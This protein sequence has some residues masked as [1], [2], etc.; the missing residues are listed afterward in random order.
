MRVGIV[1]DEGHAL[2]TLQ[3]FF[4]KYKEQTRRHIKVDAFQDSVKFI[5]QYRMIYDLLL[6]DIQMPDLDG[7][8]LAEKIRDIDS[9]VLIIFVTNM[10]QYAVKGYKVGAL[11]Y[12]LKPVTYFEF[13]TALDKAF[14]CLDNQESVSL[15]IS[16]K[17]EKRR[18]LASDIIY[19]EILNHK[20]EFHMNEETIEVW[21][22]L[23]SVESELPARMFSK[24]NAGTIVNL[25]MVVGVCDDSVRLANGE[26]LPVSR[27]RKKEFCADLAFFFGE[28][29]YV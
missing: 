25:N 10:S 15:I 28:K 12:L 29:S 9:K 20:L 3:N 27:R 18:L 13:S 16:T 24:V 14:R 5:G 22:T 4:E 17:R 7:M 23:A 8:R 19:I 1:E 6:L 26:K 21:G 11:D 2:D